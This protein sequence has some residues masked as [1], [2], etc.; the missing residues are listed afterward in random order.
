MLAGY[1]IVAFVL[2]RD[3][4]RAK[5]FYGETLG[6]EFVSQD[7]FAV[8][9]NAHGIMLRISIMPNHTPAQYTV[10]GWNVPDIKAAAAELTAAGITLEKYGFPG[11]DEQG[12]WTPPDG[13]AKVAWFKDPDGNV[14]SIS[15]H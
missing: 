13:S 10:L 2:T 9:F 11:Q 4:A 5:Q 12:I 3:P 6:L 15:Q 8:V 7:N 14:L 1:P